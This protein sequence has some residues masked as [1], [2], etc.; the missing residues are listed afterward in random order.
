MEFEWFNVITAGW[1]AGVAL[2]G[3]I[4]IV[5]LAV[6]LEK[7]AEQGK[8]NQD[9]ERPGGDSGPPTTKVEAKA[10][11]SAGCFVGCLR[12]LLPYPGLVLVAYC[13]IWLIFLR[14]DLVEIRPEL[15][16]R[17]GLFYQ[18]GADE[19]FTGVSNIIGSPKI[20]GR[21]GKVQGGVR[22]PAAFASSFPAHQV[23]GWRHYRAGKLE[24]EV[25]DGPLF[26]VGKL[27]VERDGRHYIGQSTLPINGQVYAHVFDFMDWDKALKVTTYRDG[28]ISGVEYFSDVRQRKLQIDPAEIVEEGSVKGNIYYSGELGWTL[29]IPTGWSVLDREKMAELEA[30]TRMLVEDYDRPKGLINRV[31]IQKDETNQFIAYTVPHKKL[32]GAEND[33]PIEAQKEMYLDLYQQNGIS[34]D[35][36]E[37]ETVV[38][39]GLDFKWFEMKFREPEGELVKTLRCYSRQMDQGNIMVELIFQ[40]PDWCETM[41]THWLDS[42]FRQ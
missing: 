18:P 4:A 38:I 36:G 30:K 22:G 16:Q 42:K 9:D 28:K 34:V 37:T 12:Y 11:Q 1:F 10:P 32:A 41:V 13:L 6:C 8:P 29:E 17:D 19:P 3:L 14:G 33:H 2:I 21:S 31:S 24:T 26:N 20:L 35:V 23:I 39:D 27:I 15:V 25:F 5:L 7:W 40:N